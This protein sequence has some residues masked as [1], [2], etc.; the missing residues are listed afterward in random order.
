MSV[1]LTVGQAGDNP[2]LVPLLD[3]IEVARPGGGRPRSPP[4]AVV[5]HKTYSHPSTRVLLRGRGIRFTCPERADQKATRAA[6]GSRGGRPPAFDRVEYAGR[7]VVVR[8]INRLEHFRDL[9]TRYAERAA[10]FRS[11][12]IIAATILW[13]Q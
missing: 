4:E 11:A 7:N 1:I 3:R 2:Q 13:L 12:L 5:A 6:K 9:A 10:Y 8:C